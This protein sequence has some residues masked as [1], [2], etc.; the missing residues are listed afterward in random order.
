MLELLKAKTGDTFLQEPSAV[1][2][3][4][5]SIHMCRFRQDGLLPTLSTGS[6]MFVPRLGR[7][8]ALQELYFLMGFPVSQL[9]TQLR[10]FKPHVLRRF[11]GNTMHCDV[12]GYVLLASLFLATSQ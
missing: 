6:A 9:E 7:C 8:L 12:V 1:L 3:V 11:V 4:S 10:D 2:D 5:Q